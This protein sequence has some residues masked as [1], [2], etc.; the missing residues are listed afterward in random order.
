MNTREVYIH[1]HSGNHQVEKRLI[2]IRRLSRDDQ[3]HTILKPAHYASGRNEF[4]VF[5]SDLKEICSM[6][7]K[8]DIQS[9]L[10][11]EDATINTNIHWAVLWGVPE[12]CEC[13]HLKVWHIMIESTKR[14]YFCNHHAHVKLLAEA[15]RAN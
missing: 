2:D 8:K 12:T 6:L 14:H 11:D 5:R 10:Q 13:C 7:G 15:L 9:W 1:W 3:M 4:V